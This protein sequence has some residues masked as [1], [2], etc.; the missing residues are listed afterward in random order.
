[1]YNDGRFRKS[2]P[3]TA[4][5]RP[6]CAHGRHFFAQDVMSFFPGGGGPSSGA[7]FCQRRPSLREAHYS[8]LAL[9]PPHG[10]TS[11]RRLRC[12]KEPTSSL[13]ATYAPN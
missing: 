4:N 12:P 6:P 8:G 11:L 3:A 10:A 9:P 13:T 7:S 1:M 5:P 2:R